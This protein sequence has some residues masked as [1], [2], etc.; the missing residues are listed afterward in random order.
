[1]VNLRGGFFRWLALESCSSNGPYGCDGGSNQASAR[2]NPATRQKSQA[3]RG[4]PG[5]VLEIK[6]NEAQC[7]VRACKL[8]A[9]GIYWFQGS[10]KSSMIETCKTKKEQQVGAD[11]EQSKAGQDRTGQ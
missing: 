6:P 11:A 7:D 8:E 10:K 4:L 1:M 3:R 2:Q 9:K 5:Q